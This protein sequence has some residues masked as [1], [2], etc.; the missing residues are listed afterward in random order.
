MLRRLRRETG[1]WVWSQP[2]LLDLDGHISFRPVRY[3]SGKASGEMGMLNL[4]YSGWGGRHESRENLRVFNKDKLYPAILWPLL[5]TV[6][7]LSAFK[8][9][10]NQ[11]MRA[12]I[13]ICVLPMPCHNLGLFLRLTPTVADASLY[14]GII[15]SNILE[16]LVTQNNLCCKDNVLQWL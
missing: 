5:N 11:G 15:C 7:C 10:G 12:D 16:I 13:S 6:K 8:T 4:W 1:S 9:W 2:G 14:R 3:L